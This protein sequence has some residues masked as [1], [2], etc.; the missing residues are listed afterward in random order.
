MN[1]TTSFKDRVVSVAISW[2]RANG[3][4]TIACAS[5]GNLANAV[6]A[7]SARAGLECFVFIPVDLEPA[8]VVSISVLDP[9]VAAGRGNYDEVNRL[10]SQLLESTPRASCNI[11]IPPYPTAASHSPPI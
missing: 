3:F 5:T 10:R 11:N 7:Y 4:E 2:A 8:K 1:P 9:N 6:P